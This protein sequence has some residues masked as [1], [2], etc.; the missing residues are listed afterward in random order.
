MCVSVA[1][2]GC[3]IEPAHLERIFERLHQES[4]AERHSRKG[5]GL[6]LAICKELIERQGGEIWAESRVG[7][8]TAFRFTLPVFAL[9]ATLRNAIV[10][11]GR[12]RPRCALLRAVL[13]AG[14]AESGLPESARR[15]VRHRLKTAV[16]EDR[17]VLLPRLA[18]SVDRET[19][20]LLAATDEAGARSIAERVERR[21]RSEAKLEKLD[22]AVSWQVAD[23]AGRNDPGS[24]A[25]A[26]EAAVR[27][28]RQ[29]LDLEGNEDGGNPREEPQDSDHR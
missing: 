14:D 1:D 19:F 3:G 11:E 2:T 18:W 23:F 20:W 13:V 28:L 26:I 22:F 5:L 8:G 17:D 29:L 16:Y 7:E 27:R 6:G 24:D 4:N 15:L 21:L 10:K 25:D 9:D 12:L